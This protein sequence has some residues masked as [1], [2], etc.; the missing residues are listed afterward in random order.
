MKW[1]SDYLLIIH[2]YF[3][4]NSTNLLIIQNISKAVLPL[5]WINMLLSGS[6]KKQCNLSTVFLPYYSGKILDSEDFCPFPELIKGTI[7]RRVNNVHFYH[8]RN[9]A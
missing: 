7:P 8:W 1:D 4:P 2:Q 5:T 6:L 3:K 9:F